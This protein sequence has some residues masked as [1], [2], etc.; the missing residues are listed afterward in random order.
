MPEAAQQPPQSPRSTRRPPPRPATLATQAVYAC[1][2]LLVGTLPILAY[3]AVGAGSVVNAIEA[4]QAR[5]PQL[6]AMN[7]MISCAVLLA[8]PFEFFAAI[9][10]IEGR[11]GLGDF[12]RRYRRDRPEIA[13]TGPLEG[14]DDG[15][16][17]AERSLASERS[18]DTLLPK[19]APLEIE[20]DTSRRRCASAEEEELLRDEH[21]SVSSARDA[22]VRVVGL[23]SLLRLAVVCA[24]AAV[25][26]LVPDLGLAISL[27]GSLEAPMLVLILPPLL[28][29][30]VLRPAAGR[31]LVNHAIVLCGVL[32]AISGT[33]ESVTKIASASA[34]AAGAAALN[35]HHQK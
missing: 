8:Y 12:T 26:A 15:T 2:I 9:E 31:R 17:E 7:A 24:T 27:F 33:F 10:V 29:N 14:A 18:T 1:T 34:S 28:A 32:G 22:H 3:G 20:T 6:V 21:V 16:G 5:S 19:V 23:R 4:T 11:L 13:G 25:A 35:H 30:A